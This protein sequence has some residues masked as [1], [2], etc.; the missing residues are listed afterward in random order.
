MK[1]DFTSRERKL[2]QIVF[3]LT[4]DRK[5]MTERIVIARYDEA[6]RRLERGFGDVYYDKVRP[7]GS[8][9]IGFERDKAGNWN[10]NAAI[11]RESYGKVIPMTSARWKHASLAAEYL[12]KKGDSGEPSALFAAMN[13]W[14]HYL[15]CFNF[16]HGTHLL[17]MRL[18]ML[19][20]PFAIFD[21]SK[22]WRED[23]AKILSCATHDGEST[24]EIWY[25]A[26]KRVL[27]CV[28][29]SASLLPVIVYYLHK[30]AE[31]RYVFQQCKVCGRAFLARSR[32]YE[33]CSDKCR[34][35]QAA[36][37]KREF[38]ERVKEDRVEQLDEAAYFY[39]YNRLRKLRKGKA[40]NPDK[41]AAFK[42]A[43]DGFRK[44][45]VKRKSAVKRGETTLSDFCTWLAE[46]QNEA[47]RLMEA[48]IGTFLG[49]LK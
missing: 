12:R 42:V 29:A 24:V 9:L 13:T 32:H 5:K 21:V 22:P 28:I 43:F 26:G 35:V 49:Q 10:K 19:Y 7:L 23:A 4:L 33:L 20:K 25:P 15:T 2:G 18:T 1:Y 17:T 34:K 6:R 36:E 37:A 31:W 16:N 38:D 47:D 48:E 3:A 11:L 39:W 27:E 45:A 40:A 8:L 14:D 30:I 44:E 46:R 41:A